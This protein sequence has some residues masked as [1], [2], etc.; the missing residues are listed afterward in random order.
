MY[1]TRNIEIAKERIAYTR[2]HQLL[3]L[4]LSCLMLHTIP[5]DI[6]DLFYL[7]DIDLS[8]NQL[9]TIP[10]EIL[11][12]QNLQNLNLSFNCLTYIDFE[13]SRQ[14][15]FKELDISNNYFYSLPE[16]VSN[17]NDDMFVNYH[18][19]PFLDFLPPEIENHSFEHVRYYLE[20]LR[21]QKEINGIYETKLIFVGG[22]EV[23]KTTLMKVLKEESYFV[24]L[25]LEPT[26]HGIQI[27]SFSEKVFFPAR[28]PF[29]NSFK[30][31]ED[32]YILN[33][34]VDRNED[35]E[36]EASSNDAIDAK[37]DRFLKPYIEDNYFPFTD[38]LS[39]Y[40][41]EDL[42]ELMVTTDLTRIYIDSVVEKPI[43]INLWDFGGQEIYHS[44]HQFFLTKR[45]IYIFVWEPRKDNNEDD[46][47]YWLNVIKLLSVESPVIVVMNKSDI[48]H[49]NI[50]KNVYQSK[51]KNITAF[52]SI[53]CLTKDGIPELKNEIKRCIRMLP[54][55]GDKI[56]FSWN[57]MRESIAALKSDFISY[58]SFA[59]LCRANQQNISKKEIHLFSEYLHDIGAIIHFKE[60]SILRNL[61]IINPQW[62]TKAV[63]TLIDTIPI[64]K[65]DGVF[66]IFELDNY[67]DLTAYPQE[68]HIEILQLME[69][70]E[71]CFKL[72]GGKDIYVIPELLK[73]EIPNAFVIAEIESD[74]TLKFQLRYS[75]FPHGIIT[76]LICRLYNIIFQDCYWKNGVILQHE[77]SKGS[78]ISDRANKTI[79]ISIAGKQKSNLLAIIRNELKNI[80]Q[81]FNMNEGIDFNELLPCNCAVCASIPEPYYINYNVLKKFIAN[82]KH[83]ID[84]HLSA[85]SIDI[86]KLI[87]GYTLTK[88]NIKLIYEILS[89]ASQLQGQHQIILKDEDARNSFISSRLSLNGIISKDQSR[90]GASETGKSQG[91][92][93]IKI[94]DGEGNILTIFEGLNLKALDVTKIDSHISKTLT[95]YDPNGLFEKYI[96]IYY[97]GVG[98]VNFCN[99]YFSHISQDNPFSVFK[100][101]VDESQAILQHTEIKVFKSTYERTAREVYLYHILINMN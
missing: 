60:D 23:G 40:E 66:S 77:L 96:C 13:D 57:K 17:L 65:K 54:H 19:N 46:F 1:N 14:Y 4:D 53:S 56:P 28:S 21:N 55:I 100:S 98:F 3:Y 64:Q 44:T 93:D 48:R 85:Q 39:E 91:R 30:S 62:A 45:S 89:A 36:D 74:E 63:Y 24:E 68:R 69:K 15:S 2:K 47:E 29:Y 8:H 5:E 59:D 10:S 95:H 75:F 61:V 38:V 71:I 88:P 20:L 80:H 31:I 35:E 101:T 78:V 42:A 83:T 52:L 9:S 33:H 73:I 99:K 70:F 67:W 18:D 86:I 22:G 6:S 49:K 34:D 50:D 58:Q 41:E 26:T 87:S 32:V 7:L 51:F 76:R 16:S 27:D 11:K 90:W 25:G 43:K 82:D 84:C 12:F 37:F 92:L 97:D 81:S 79:T 94:E 72:M